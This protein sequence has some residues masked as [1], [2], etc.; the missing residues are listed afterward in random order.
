[1]SMDALEREIFEIEQLLEQE[2]QKVK[3]EGIE[4]M[5][6]R[7]MMI[8]HIKEKLSNAQYT[9]ARF[10]EKHLPEPERQLEAYRERLSFL[11][12]LPRYQ[13]IDWA[14][15]VLKFPNLLIVAIDKFE[16]ENEG[17]FIRF[18]ALDAT[19]TVCFDRFVK[20]SAP[21]LSL[22]DSYDTY[23]TGVTLREIEEAPLLQDVWT[24]LQGTFSGKYIVTYDITEFREQLQERSVLRDLEW[25]VIFGASLGT[26]ASQYFHRRRLIPL[27]ELC[28]WVGC[29]LPPH[30]QQTA[31][32]RAMA[33][34]YI[35]QAMAQGVITI[36]AKV[37]I[38]YKEWMKNEEEYKKLAMKNNRKMTKGD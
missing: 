5:Q 21:P 35:L 2:E 15:Q 36:R 18:L 38:S 12:K 25:P 20:P 29:P 7:K 26:Q 19:G 3:I 8:A 13:D 1:M 28:S 11:A 34:L 32:H 17:D 23:V 4:D 14:R 27:D 37:Q 33:Y 16:D 24:D 30:P 6:A 22:Y 31:V 9:L 10:R